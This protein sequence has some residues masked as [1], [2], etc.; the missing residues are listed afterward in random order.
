MRVKEKISKRKATGFGDEIEFTFKQSAKAFN[1]LVSRLYNDPIKAILRELSCN[2]Y[3][4]QVEAGNQDKPMLVHLPNRLEPQFWIRDYGIGLSQEDVQEIYTKVFE[5]TKTAS[6]EFTGCLG[7]GS[8]TPFSYTNNFIVESFYNGKHYIYNAYFN[9]AGV[10]CMAMLDGN[11]N[12][13]DEPNGVKITISVK[14]NDFENWRSKAEEIYEYFAVVPKVIG[15]KI[16]VKVPNYI[17]EGENWK[18]RKSEFR[19]SG[20]KV[21]MGNVAYPISD[22]TDAGLNDV[23]RA[24]MGCNID[25]FVNIGDVEMEASREGL[26]FDKRT[27][28]VIKQK[29]DEVVEDSKKEISKCFNGCVSLWEARCKYMDLTKN[30]PREIL[31]AVGMKQITYNGEQLFSDSYYKDIYLPKWSDEYTIYNFKKHS[32]YYWRNNSGKVKKTTARS[33][34]ADESIKFYVNDMK[35]GSFIRCTELAEREDCEVI[36]CKFEDNTK[37]QEFLDTVGI[38]ESDFAYT[39]TLPKPQQAPRQGRAKTTK[40]S[41]FSG[42]KSFISHCWEN[43]DDVDLDKGGYYVEVNRHRIVHHH[44]SKVDVGSATNPKTKMVNNKQNMEPSSLSNILKALEICGYKLPVVYGVKTS[45]IAKVKKSKGN[46]VNVLD[47]A[48]VKIPHFLSTFNT[49]QHKYNARALRDMESELGNNLWTL[50]KI[51]DL[52]SKD[53]EVHTF[54][55]K[56]N[57]LKISDLYSSKCHTLETAYRSLFYEDYKSDAAIQ[58]GV[59]D[60]AKSI[61]KRY[62][63]LDEL[64]RWYSND[65]LEHVALYVD[66]V[67]KKESN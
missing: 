57:S 40:I 26:H 50:E 64:G 46:W 9:E 30:F 11:G 13:T 15:N 42:S 49:S 31:D 48:K 27:I 28:N 61:N 37:K 60:Y 62:K 32:R 44:K 3:D 33:I 7:L 65:C 66:A 10:P 41:R 23:H 21:V 18:L 25:L 39:S 51:K 36:L 47:F 2:G 35:T 59:V 5:S 43:E 20:M 45:M 34:K 16:N 6:N 19:G 1:I 14:N 58:N 63:L 56:R 55:K 8:K 38:L 67:D 22:F 24:M 52:I 12:D 4:A 53:S 54:F 17:M 29:I